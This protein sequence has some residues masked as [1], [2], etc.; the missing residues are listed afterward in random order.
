VFLAGLGAPQFRRRRLR[1]HL[2]FLR[3]KWRAHTIQQA[4]LSFHS[5]EDIYGHKSRRNGQLAKRYRRLEGDHSAV[6]DFSGEVY[7]QL[8][9]YNRRWSVEMT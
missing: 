1:E 8:K 6:L 9:H 4:L 3:F 7:S 2:E 5:Q